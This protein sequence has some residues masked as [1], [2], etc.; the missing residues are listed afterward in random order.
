MAKVECQQF[1]VTYPIGNVE[2]NQIAY[3]TINI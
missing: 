3:F 1:N 2:F